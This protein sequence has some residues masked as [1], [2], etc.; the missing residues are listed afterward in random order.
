MLILKRTVHIAVIVFFISLISTKSSGQ[1]IEQLCPD[2]ALQLDQSNY[3]D[4]I[5]ILEECLTRTESTEDSLLMLLNKARA[6]FLQ[7]KTAGGNEI[8]DNVLVEKY[9]KLYKARCLALEWRARSYMMSDKDLHLHYWKE[10]DSVATANTFTEGQL[11]ASVSIGN[12]YYTLFRD[13]NSAY[14]Y[15]IKALAFENI[16]D[17]YY[18][19]TVSG[20]Y[21]T[22]FKL[23]KENTDSIYALG[24]AFIDRRLKEDITSKDS[25]SI[26]SFYGL[27]GNN[28]LAKGDFTSALEHNLRAVKY[29]PKTKRFQY[30]LARLY[31][32]IARI[33]QALSTKDH[34][35]LQLRHLRSAFLLILR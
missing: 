8:L 13:L 1:Y 26:G 32:N 29:K 12:A 3:E 17:D 15:L 6:L 2:A 27:V 5:L 21:D 10:S 14:P 33:F 24:I 25:S 20:A 4:A 9:S 18:L 22:S 7:R 35:L 11:R 16:P 19:S 23:A 34:H 30:S 31:F 28:L